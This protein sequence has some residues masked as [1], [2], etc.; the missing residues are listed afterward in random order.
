MI[1][2]GVW[3]PDESTFWQSWIDRGICTAPK[4]FAPSYR[5]IETTHTWD[6]IVK[7]QT[8]VDQD[9]NPIME[10]VPGWHTNVRVSGPLEAQFT[11][12]KPS[13]G[14]IWERTHAAAVFGL[15]YEAADSV[16]GFPEGMRSSAGVVYADASAFNSPSNVWA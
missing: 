5:Y 15:T 13:T 1:I 7:K 3:S 9:G 6:G 12:G 8:G 16:T 2:F 14:T 11:A 4:V 10:A